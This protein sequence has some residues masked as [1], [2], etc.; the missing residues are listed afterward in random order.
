MPFAG[1]HLLWEKKVKKTEAMKNKND[2]CFLGYKE[3]TTKEKCNIHVFYILIS[4]SKSHLLWRVWWAWHENIDICFLILMFYFPFSLNFFITS[5]IGGEKIW[6]VDVSIE[7]I[8][9]AN[10][11]TKFLAT[12]Q[13]LK[14]IEKNLFFCFLRW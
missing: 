4:L 11:T 9:K 13:K 8:K 6:I 2:V 1:S 5:I 14:R 12:N 7:N 3:K 10:W